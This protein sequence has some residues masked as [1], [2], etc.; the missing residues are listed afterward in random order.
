MKS[1]VLFLFVFS[2]TVCG[3]TIED[4]AESV[5]T[6]TFSSSRTPTILLG[7]NQGGFLS[8]YHEFE[9]G[10]NTKIQVLDG[11]GIPVGEAT[12]AETNIM[13]A[14]LFPDEKFIV[15][16]ITSAGMVGYQLYMP[17]ENGYVNQGNG[18]TYMWGGIDQPS[19]PKVSVLPNGDH[20]VAYRARNTNDQNRFEIRMNRHSNNGNGGDTS[21][22]WQTDVRVNTVT[23]AMSEPQIVAL[24]N[25]KFVIAYTAHYSSNT[26][27]MQMFNTYGNKFGSEKTVNADGGSM[28]EMRA[29]GCEDSSFIISYRNSTTIF[30]QRFDS[31]GNKVGSEQNFPIHPTSQNSDLVCL[32]DNYVAIIHTDAV[33][34]TVVERLYKSD[35]TFVSSTVINALVNSVSIQRKTPVATIDKLDGKRYI[36]SW[37]STSQRE[38]NS[39][40]IYVT[41]RK[42]LSWAWTCPNGTPYDRDEATSPNQVKCTACDSE[43]HHLN[44]VDCDLN[45]YGC[46]DDN[47]DNYRSDATHDSTCLYTYSCQ[48]GTAAVPDAE[49][50]GLEKCASCDL[51]FTLG[52]NNLCQAHSDLDC[53]GLKDAHFNEGCCASGGSEDNCGSIRHEYDSKCNCNPNI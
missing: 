7:L 27:L 18:K 51:G 30:F 28:Y 47:A 49:E 35:G 32:R 48:N 15:T 40:D 4:F 39:H 42:L 14:A 34:R 16:T 10:S 41:G 9:Y 46:R 1:I 31:G 37:T 53:P 24:S 25:G 2:A 23:V 52:D 22:S 44:G 20:V 17:T 21:R 26:I 38:T 12:T 33:E 13:D 36:S 43:T 45:R 11:D 29:V 8:L 6:S 5:T 19:T 50:A 3:E